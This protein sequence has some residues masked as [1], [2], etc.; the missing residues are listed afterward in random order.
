MLLPKQ[1]QPV[2]RS[3]ATVR[4]DRPLTEETLTAQQAY[5]LQF[6]DLRLTCDLSAPVGQSCRWE[7]REAAYP[8]RVCVA[9]PVSRGCGANAPCPA[10]AATFQCG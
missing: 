10:C 1:A 2:I 6:S 4:S 7:R 3:K 9:C 8:A 5:D